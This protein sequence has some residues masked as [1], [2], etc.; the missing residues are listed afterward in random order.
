M[1]KL[2]EAS[3]QEVCIDFKL[4]CKCRANITLKSIHPTSPVAFKVQTSSPHKFLVNPPNGLIQPLSSTSFQVILKPQTHL[5]SSF[6]RSPSDRFLIKTALAH[7]LNTPD[8]NSINMWFSSC[9][10]VTH[11]LKLK[12][13]YMGPYL[14]RHAV[15]GGDIDAIK[16]IIKRQ[17]SIVAQLPSHEAMSLLEAASASGNVNVLNLLLEAGL[18]IEVHHAEVPN[19]VSGANPD[20]ESE[21]EPKLKSKTPQLVNEE[22]VALMESKGWTPIH[23]ASAF[24]RYD[25]LVT[26]IGDGRRDQPLDCRDK[27][28][29]TA[30]HV[31]T[32]RGHTRCVRLLIEAGADKNAKSN[33]GR[34]ALFRAAAS[35]DLE[36]VTLLLDAGADPSITTSVHGRGPLDVARDK[37][38]KDVAKILEQGELV[39]T[40]ARRGELKHL[41]SLLQKGVSMKHCDQYGLTALH[42]AAIKG[43]V[44][45]VAMLIEFGMDLELQDAEGHTPLHLAVEGGH[46]TIVEALIDRGAH[47]NARS[48]RGATPLYMA[49]SMGYDGISQMLLSRG[50]ASSCLP[51]SSSSLSSSSFT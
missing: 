47:I 41:E 17:K 48:K 19:Q 20:A 23:M 44:D 25:V 24:D 21:S 10:H 43:H 28:G 45:I 36:M 13:L 15:A 33:D 11:D 12:V 3:E 14:L 38:H 50:A 49:T 2:V 1:E 18:Q 37:G 16:Q 51:S 8:G 9:V 26:L 29:R 42:S 39:L 40:A 32:S 35:G 4:G 30:L 7:D 5:P 34:T 22:E 6:P 27:D 31:A 46:S